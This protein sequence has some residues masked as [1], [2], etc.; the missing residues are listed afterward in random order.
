MLQQ[1]MRNTTS[2]IHWVKNPCSLIGTMNKVGLS[3]SYNCVMSVSTDAANSVCICFEQDG[4]VCPSKLH[5]HL[6]TTGALHNIDH[7]P[8]T[9][10]TKDSFHSTAI[11]LVQHPSDSGFKETSSS[12]CLKSDCSLF[13]RLYITCQSCK[14]DLQEFFR[15]ENHPWPPSLSQH[16]KLRHGSFCRQPTSGCEN[17]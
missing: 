15:H 17:I 3:I 8:G 13:S 14:G 7:N 2:Y 4:V 1:R 9:T 11:L 6:F 10:T 5:K 16:G 12:C